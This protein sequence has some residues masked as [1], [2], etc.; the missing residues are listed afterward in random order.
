M[1][2]D[3]KE[4]EST[5]DHL[6]RT[7]RGASFPRMAL[8]EAVSAIQEI[9]K[10][11]RQHNQGS[12]ASALGH[13]SAKSGT[14]RQRLA[15]LREYALVAG[16]GEDLEL[17][18]LALRITHPTST[19]DAD[20]ALAVAFLNC[21]T[22]AQMYGELE[23]G[24]TIPLDR[25][26]NFS[27]HRLGVG[28][29]VAERFAESFAAGAVAAQLAERNDLGLIMWEREHAGGSRSA[30]TSTDESAPA[31]PDELEQTGQSPDLVVVLKQAWPLNNGEV[32]FSVRLTDAL[33]SSAFGPV[34]DAVSAIETFVQHL[35]DCFP[36]E[37]QPPETGNEG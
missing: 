24:E 36:E 33:P 3:E 23:K 27:I 16:R 15:D 12:L 20:G 32:Q 18:D 5:A 35:A 9:A 21:D 14:F 2:A 26:G 19:A 31:K 7:K 29:H 28:H 22:F 6:K 1:S 17:T 25:L 30:E 10:M 8:S 11:G 4:T 37:P 34:G 13:S